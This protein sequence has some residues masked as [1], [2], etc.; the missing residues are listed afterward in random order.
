MGNLD[1]ITTN[2]IMRETHARQRSIILARFPELES[3][4][5]QHYLSLNKYIARSPYKFYSTEA[6]KTYSAWLSTQ[7]KRD[8]DSIAMH[9]DSCS[10]DLN[11]V[12]IH[13]E[14]VNAYD[15][16]DHFG[17]MEDY[18]TIRFIEQ[19][20]HPAYLKLLEATFTPFLRVVAHISRLERG[21]NT[22]GLDLYNVVKEVKRVG[23]TNLTE[24]Y[25]HIIRNGIGHGHITYLMRAI[26]YTDKKGN[27]ETFETRRITYLI[28]DLLDL[29][30]GIALALSMFQILNQ[31]NGHKIL[32]QFLIDELR[33]ET[34]NPWWEV[35]G[36]VE[37]EIPGKSQLIVYVRSRTTF[38]EEIQ[39]YAF[40]TGIHAEYFARGYDRYFISFY[41]HKKQIG[42][43]ALNGD[44]MSQVRRMP[45]AKVDDYHGAIE[46]M[47]ILS[48]YK[49]PGVMRKLTTLRRS[50]KV[51]AKFGIEDFRKK[52]GW[53]SITVRHAK[54][55]RN[56]WG[57]VLNAGV[58][59]EGPQSNLTP[60]MIRGIRGRVVRKALKK[61]RKETPRHHLARYLPIGFA[62]LSIFQKDYRRR[63]LEN[64][65]LGKDL[66]GTIR[67]Q[68]I[69][70]IK[71][72][73]IYGST[74]EMVGRYRF[75]W[76]AAWLQEMEL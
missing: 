53:P 48:R 51:N 8:S 21:K 57:V 47:F 62:Q 17:S 27:S 54:I 69:K 56:S 24:P 26:K 32:N 29:C 10:A 1:H 74:L 39:F 12:F 37:A 9:I 44:K 64:Y 72:R 58:V 20:I 70:R 3:V 75:A 30:N 36:C 16:H 34:M 60:E 52:M 50:F 4:N 40:Q 63:R 65:G 19:N 42:W 7:T 35:T 76:N 59:I 46:N 49:L 13:L 68:R 45:A 73:D 43:L 23:L 2:A 5:N 71:T 66:I 18:E 67:M 41:N 25:I 15:W 38:K 22:E 31:H 14:E 61:A 33:H 6:Y 55:H 28:D 11:H